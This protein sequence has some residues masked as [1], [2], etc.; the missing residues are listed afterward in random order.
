MITP[1]PVQEGRSIRKMVMET[2]NR[3]NQGELKLPVLLQ[4]SK[5]IETVMNDPNSGANEVTDILEKDGVLTVKIIATANSALFYR[6]GE[7]I[8]D[9][10]SAITRIGIKEIQSIVSTISSKS[11]YQTGNRQFKELI[12]SLWLH[13][14]ACANCC[15]AIS[16]KL[17][18]VNTDKIFM[19]GL[20]HDIGS[21]LLLRS[22]GDMTPETL[23]LDREELL[24]SLQ[25][26]HTSFGAAILTDLGLGAEFSDC[27]KSYKWTSFNKE[28]SQEVLVLNLA[29]KIAT[30]INFGFFEKEVDWSD[31]ESA[32]LLGITEKILG[33]VAEAVTKDMKTLEGVFK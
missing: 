12:E 11:L 16:I 22:L 7:K 33:E 32:R 15:R 8:K 10:R 31:L 21:L 17:G 6:G 5:E 30:R 2:I 26:V 13:S 4:I 23:E 14:L 19:L 20:T 24:E 29:E 27:V 18:N 3:F 28:T 1:E 9:L 25:E